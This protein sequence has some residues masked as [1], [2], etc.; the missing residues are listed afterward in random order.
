MWLLL[1]HAVPANNEHCRKKSSNSNEDLTIIKDLIP[2][3][4][5]I[6][7]EQRHQ[8]YRELKLMN[9]MAEQIDVLPLPDEVINGSVELFG[10]LKIYN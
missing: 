5:S 3:T 8:I 4:K 7:V 2:T 6:S 1:S 10:Q 9:K